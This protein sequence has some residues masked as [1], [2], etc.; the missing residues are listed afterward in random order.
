MASRVLFVSIVFMT[1]DLSVVRPNCAKT[2]HKGRMRQGTHRR[3]AQPTRTL[4]GQLDLLPAAA[5]QQ[6]LDH[7]TLDRA[8]RQVAE[9]VRQQSPRFVQDSR[10]EVRATALGAENPPH[11][12]LERFRQRMICQPDARVLFQDLVTAWMIVMI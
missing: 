11:N 2:R 8:A 7:Q 5:A 3:W 12:P 4:R 10:L 6:S 1:L 9:R